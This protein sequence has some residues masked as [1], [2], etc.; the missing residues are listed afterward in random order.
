MSRI[1]WLGVGCLLASS[2][3]WAQHEGHSITTNTEIH[4]FA[5]VNAQK[6]FGSQSPSDPTLPLYKTP[7]TFRLG[8]LDFYVF[9]HLGQFSFL[10]ETGFEP[11]PD[12]Y[13]LDVERL[14]VNW[15]PASWFTFTIGRYHTPFGYWNTAYHHGRWL[16]TTVD[17]PLLFR[18]EDEGGPLPVHT[19]GVLL[20][21]D[22]SLGGGAAIHYDLGA[23]NGRGPSPDPPQKL[24]DI[25]EG[26]SVLVGLH[27]QAGG[28]R[29][30]AAAWWDNSYFFARGSSDRTAMI[31]EILAADITYTTAPF[32]LLLEGAVVRHLFNNIEV[33]NYGAYAQVAYQVAE[34]WK[35][36][37]RGE[38]Q[39]IPRQEVY[40]KL[41]ERPS[42][43]ERRALAGIRF[44]P[45]EVLAV[46]LEGGVYKLKDIDL[47]GFVQLQFAFVY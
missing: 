38:I 14:Q 6:Y 17:A 22:L 47:G 33:L 4:F 8:S 45:V 16:F 42:P 21:G 36:Y 5:D 15:S 11:T 2:T 1:I 44:D 40:L 9:S 35:P 46:K 34:R 12:G 7:S 32:E 27:L 29:A 31:E 18:F 43:D 23:G 13:S 26:K 19:I 24:Q 25:N 39:I 41:T 30:G 3:A 28:F 20:S 10:S 37:A